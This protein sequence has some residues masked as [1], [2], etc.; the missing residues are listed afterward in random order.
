MSTSSYLIDLKNRIESY[1]HSDSYLS[2]LG[3]RIWINGFDLLF[4]EASSTYGKENFV[5]EDLWYFFG[6]LGIEYI[7]IK[8]EKDNVYVVTNIEHSDIYALDGEMKLKGTTF[9]RGILEYTFSDKNGGRE[10]KIKI[11]FNKTTMLFPDTAHLLMD[12]NKLLPKKG[13]TF[14]VGVY[15]PHFWGRQIRVIRRLDDV[16]QNIPISQTKIKYPKPNLNVSFPYILSLQNHLSYLKIKNNNYREI[17]DLYKSLY[18]SPEKIEKEWKYYIRN[19]YPKYAFPF[20]GVTDPLLAIVMLDVAENFLCHSAISK[21]RKLKSIL[22]DQIIRKFFDLTES[23][24]VLKKLE[25]EKILFGN[26]TTLP[27]AIENI[28]ESY[29][30]NN[31]NNLFYN[32][33]FNDDYVMVFETMDPINVISV[34]TPTGYVNFLF[35]NTDD[36]NEVKNEFLEALD[37]K[38]LEKKA[39]KIDSFSMEERDIIEL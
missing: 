38:V 24:F 28:L 2:E 31:S 29:L 39:I 16:M 10:E 23:D 34:I 21:A 1:N 11:S 17:Y 36:K 5:P 20:I 13:E 27:Y 30:P 35:E 9:K 3:K 14:I 37:I 6:D 22:K 25:A 26:F 19:T 15:L 33:V 18:F 4:K 7:Y 12:V 8:D 32:Y